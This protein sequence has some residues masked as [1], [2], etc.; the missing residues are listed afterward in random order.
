[1]RNNHEEKFRIVRP[2]QR[3]VIK[4]TH[5]LQTALLHLRWR[6]LLLCR[7]LPTVL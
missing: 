6:I 1:M 7:H 5:P 3:L 2:S 4:L